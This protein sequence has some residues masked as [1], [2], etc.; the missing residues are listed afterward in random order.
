MSES[1]MRHL[2][3]L[4]RTIGPRGSCTEGERQAREYCR[5]VFEDMGHETRTE[6]FRSHGSAYRPF[7]VATVAILLSEW[8]FLLSEA[9]SPLAA[10]V[11]GIVMV[12]ALLDLGFISNN[13]LRWVLPVR[14]SGNVYAV[15]PSAGDPKGKLVIMAHADT[16]RTPWI[17]KSPAT[18]RIYR[19]LS[20]L[21]IL[22][23]ISCFLIYA[24]SAF[25]PSRTLTLLSL[26]PAIVVLDILVMVVQAELTPH[27]VGANDNASGV[28]FV[29]SMAERLKKDPLP[30]T[31][32]WLVV[33]GCE[34]V[35]A[36]GSRE[37]VNRHKQ[38]LA[39]ADFIIIDGIGAQGSVPHY[40][41][42]ETLLRPLTYPKEYLEIVKEVAA[43]HPQLD[44]RPFDMKGAYTDGAPVLMAGL[45]C[46]TFVNHDPSG[47]IPQWHRPSD[48]LD[49]IDPEVLSRAEGFIQEVIMKIS[50]AGHSLERRENCS[51]SS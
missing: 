21:G 29:L 5:K 28:A 18:Y 49:N 48:N 50:R 41:T 19:F 10:A 40:L 4:C 7:I 24:I 35:G 6:G 14:Q 9:W 45:K 13:P 27:T 3:H 51:I 30:S 42:R 31:R 36:D 22:A 11:T 33:T 26:I 37:F 43:E 23:F 8:L 12:S 32:V 47:W 1:T 20:T 46:L 39:D 44:V 16:H 38:E 25:A 2:E 17:W 34:E 15:V